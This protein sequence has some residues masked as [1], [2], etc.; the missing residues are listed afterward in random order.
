MHRF[1]QLTTESD[2]VSRG[3]AE[4]KQIIRRVL[5]IGRLNCQ[6]VGKKIHWVGFRWVRYRGVYWRNWNLH[7]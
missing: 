5:A 4:W 6:W 3:M 1:E 7:A 2:W